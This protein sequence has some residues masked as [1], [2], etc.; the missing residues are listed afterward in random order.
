M[1]RTN[2]DPVFL[3]LR[4]LLNSP[5]YALQGAGYLINILVSSSLRLGPSR[6]LHAVKAL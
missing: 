2:R 3:S 1:A 5:L 6:I 4:N